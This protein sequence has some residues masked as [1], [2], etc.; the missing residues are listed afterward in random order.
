MNAL[1]S[2]SR[3]QSSIVSEKGAPVR[4]KHSKPALSEKNNTIHPYVRYVQSINP[5]VFFYFFFPIF[6]TIP[7]QTSPTQTQTLFLTSRGGRSKKEKMRRATAIPQRINQLYTQPN[8]DP[9][10]PASPYPSLIPHA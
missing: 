10:H 6:H 4:K 1:T 7:P 8:P 2:W 5:P 9:T 3:I